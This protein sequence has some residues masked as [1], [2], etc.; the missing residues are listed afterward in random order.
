M[1]ITGM[2][3]FTGTRDIPYNILQR[4]LKDTLVTLDPIA[5]QDFTGGQIT[6]EVHVYCDG[7]ELENN[8]DYVVTYANNVEEGTATV[9]IVAPRNSFYSDSITT[10]F[11]IVKNFIGLMGDVDGD[12]IVNSADALSI[13]RASVSAE[14]FSDIQTKLADVNGDNTVDAADSLAVLRFS[15]QL[16][17]SGVSINVQATK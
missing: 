1:R 9:T 6:P 5:D 16:M 4:S 17:D 14:T 2:G 10:E 15:V 8:V 13:L 12:E 11:D 7:V 3:L